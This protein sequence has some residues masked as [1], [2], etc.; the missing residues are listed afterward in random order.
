ML[1]LDYLY[2]VCQD[3]SLLFSSW[4][5]QTKSELQGMVHLHVFEVLM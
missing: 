3:C 2:A 1:Q 5:V 4:K